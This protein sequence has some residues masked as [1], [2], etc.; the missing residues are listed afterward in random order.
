MSTIKYPKMPD[1]NVHKKLK[2]NS[3]LNHITLGT[4]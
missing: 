3:I 4:P 1:S 2:P